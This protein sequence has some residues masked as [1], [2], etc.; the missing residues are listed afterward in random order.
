MDVDESDVSP[1]RDAHM[2]SNGGTENE[3][4]EER[5]ASGS[6]FSAGNSEDV[7]KREE[8]DEEMEEER[9]NAISSSTTNA[10]AVNGNGHAGPSGA[11]SSRNGYAASGRHANPAVSITQDAEMDPD[12][13]GLRRSV[14]TPSGWQLCKGMH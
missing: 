7:K 3:E 4:D 2:T 14:S 8:E 10:A 13:Y 6:E 5:E 9:L 1:T 11:S 12:L